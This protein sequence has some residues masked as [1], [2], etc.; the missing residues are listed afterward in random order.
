MSI[1]A[2]LARM[3]E[4]IPDFHP[5]LPAHMRCEFHVADGLQ[6]S[7]FIEKFLPNPVSQASSADSKQ[8]RTDGWKA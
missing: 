2:L 8:L 1:G 4:N 5:V 6:T 3:F 7:G